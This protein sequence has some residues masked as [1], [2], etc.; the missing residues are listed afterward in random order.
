[1]SNLSEKK[2]IHYLKITLIGTTSNRDAI[3]ATVR[4]HCG[5]RI[6]TRFNDGKSGYLGQS[7]MPL[8][9]GLADATN[10]DS[11]EILWPSGTRQTVAQDLAINKLLTIK[12]AR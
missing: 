11:I 10:I 8:Y 4:V 5:S 6:Y 2:E 3:G 7:S 1:V 12:E 9:F